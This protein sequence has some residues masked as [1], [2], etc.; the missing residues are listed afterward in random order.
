MSKV[1]TC[2]ERAVYRARR[3]HY[4][5]VRDPSGAV[6]WR[7]ERQVERCYRCGLEPGHQGPHYDA[8]NMV[9]WR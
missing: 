9:Q 3:P 1:Q 8:S 6:G 2:G 7:V 5:A 4:A